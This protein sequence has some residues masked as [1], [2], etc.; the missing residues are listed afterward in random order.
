MIA[1]GPVSARTDDGWHLRGE[2]LAEGRRPAVALLLHA[3]MASRRSMDKPRGAGLASTLA[4]AGLSVVS[5]DLRGHGESGPSAREG[6]RYTY[7][8]YVLFDVPALVGLTRSLFPDKRV[9]V[10][11]H[12]LGAHAALAS[13]GVFPD[14]APDAIASIA[15]NFWFPSDEPSLA[16]RAAKAAVL[17]TWLAVT[18]TIGHFDPKPFR[19]GTDAVALP[20]IRQFWKVWSSDRYGS[21]DDR[22]DYAEALSRV[23]CPVLAVASEGDKLLAHPES[24]ARFFARIGSPNKALRIVTHAEHEGRA[25]DHMGLVTDPRSLPVWREIAEWAASLA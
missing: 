23:T 5:M 9:M 14:K 7:D 21:V 18:E 6:A 20:Y 24:V 2:V 3:M 13:A 25:P 10:V 4:A 11:G 12:S 17:R 15:G 19:I 16:R 22:Y 1:I 8:D